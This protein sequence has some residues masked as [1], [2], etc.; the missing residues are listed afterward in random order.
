[1]D[2]RVSRHRADRD[3]HSSQPVH[4]SDY[5]WRLEQINRTWTFLRFFVAAFCAWLFLHMTFGW[6]R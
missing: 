6:L 3:P 1:M 2:C 4:L 5:V